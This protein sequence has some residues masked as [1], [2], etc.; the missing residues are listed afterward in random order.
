MLST[1]DVGQ[2]DPIALWMFRI[3][4][5]STVG[6][7]V[8]LRRLDLLIDD[9]RERTLIAA[10]DTMLHD[11]KSELLALAITADVMTILRIS[12][13][14]CFVFGLLALVNKLDD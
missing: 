1:G 5:L 7:D 13:A 8:R 2:R 10:I 12:L 11:A 4:P 6:Q 9:A 3:P 14:H